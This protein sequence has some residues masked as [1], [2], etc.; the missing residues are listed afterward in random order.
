MTQPIRHVYVHVPFCARRCVYC[1]FSIAVRRTIPGSRYARAVLEEYVLRRRQD[2][3]ALSIETLYFGGGTPSLLPVDDFD[4][5][6]RQL[7]QSAGATEQLEV[8]LEANPENVTATTAPAWRRA[9]VSRVSLGVQSF[10]SRALVWMHRT[11]DA[12][13]TAAAVR[14]LRHAGIRRLSLDLIFALPTSL[15]VDFADELARAVE[16]EPE[17]L[18]VYGLTVE[19]RTALSRWI[20]RGAVRMASDSRYAEQFMQAHEFLTACG[21]E[22]YEVSNYARAGCR[23]LHNSAYWSGRPYLG[24]GP[25]AHSFDGK[26]R[27]WNLPS[28]PAY[29]ERAVTGGDPTEGIETLSEAEA[30]LERA[31][32]RLRT[33]EGLA[34]AEMHLV[35]SVVGREAERQGWLIRDAQGVRLTAQGWLSLDAA[36]AALTTSEQSG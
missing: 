7:L 31:Y 11:H 15:R 17:H 8:T 28:W 23:A 32:L 4:L 5:V 36:V 18:S 14:V 29:E 9:G 12:A 30:A 6:A 13:D 21:Y 22:H 33:V 25:S 26:R 3:A 16:L 27:R 10:E 1:D 19:P 34:A 20:A 35:D 24:L 2:G